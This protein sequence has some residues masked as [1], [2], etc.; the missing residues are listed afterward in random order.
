MEE[1]ILF[2]KDKQREFI[3]E[4]ILNLNLASLR[5]LLQLGLDINY[6][7]LKNY[8]SNRRLMPKTLYHSLC[9]LG[10]IGVN[11]YKVKSLDFFW[12]QSK[13][14]KAKKTKDKIN[15]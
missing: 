11:K 1:R 15:L 9:Y 5:G 14:G 8:Y 10:R 4:V 6:S 12:G 2:D 7:T 3:N 13:G